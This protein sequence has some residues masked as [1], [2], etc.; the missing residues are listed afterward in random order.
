MKTDLASSLLRPEARA[1]ID[2]AVALISRS[3]RLVAL[4]GA[5]VST[6][7]GIPDYRD[8]HGEWKRKPPLRYQEF[9]S[10]EKAR[11]RY[12]ARSAVGFRVVHSA[13]PNDAH[14]VLAGLERAG[15]LAHLITQNVDGLHQKAGTRNVMDLH[16]RV[17]RVRCL[18]CDGVV[19]REDHQR[20][21]EA[22]N[23]SWPSWPSWKSGSFTSAPDGDADLEGVDYD[24]FHFPPCDDCGG[25]LKP[26]VVFFGESVPKQRVEESMA[27]LDEADLLLVA[28][29]SLMVWSGYR[30][31][32]RALARGIPV[33]SV[34]LGRTRADEELTLKLS[35]SCGSALRAIAA[36]LP[37]PT[38]DPSRNA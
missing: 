15:R 10:N 35:L 25:L 36:A 12:W 8:Q 9:V 7:S 22:L 21:L 29:S 23:P 31:V 28:G 34:N 3:R 20:R 26:D 17:D 16:G 30:F 24:Q 11:R 13:S 27:Q 38:A 6:E 32:K 1:L 37:G 14:H 5:G 2:D 33:L 4:T 18:D 19:A